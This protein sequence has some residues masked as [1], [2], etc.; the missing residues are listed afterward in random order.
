MNISRQSI[1]DLN[2]VLTVQITKEDYAPQVEKILK[3]YQKTANIPGFRKGHVPMGMIKKQYGKAVLLDEINK[4]MQ[5]SLNSYITQEKLEI[6]GNP[7]PI[8]NPDFD[9]DKEDFSFDFEIGLSP[10]FEVNLKKN[11]ITK[12]K[13]VADTTFLD[14]QIKS[15]R[16]SYGK[17]IAKETVEA[18]DE[19]TGVFSNEEKN[20]NNKATFSLERIKG[21]KQKEALLGKKPGDSVVL[22]TKNLFVDEHD[23]QQYLGV[24]HEQ[25]HGLDIEVSL[26]IEE[27][28]TYELAEIN[29][30]LWDKVFGKDVVKSE[31]EAREKIKGDAEKQFEQY[32]DQVLLNEVVESLIAN[33]QFDLPKDFLIK[34]LEN[35]GEQPMDNE[36]AAA[37]YERTEKGLRYQLIEAKIMSENNLYANFEELKEYA[38]QMIAA[39]M[40]QYGRMDAEDQELETIAARILSNQEEVKRLA[41]QLNQSKMLKFFKENTQLEEKE[42]SYDKFTQE[43]YH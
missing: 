4:L 10:K 37:E 30:E 39:Q 35:G 31:K 33:T 16:K 15:I 24:S 26:T 7:L 17:L 2:A 36:E 1:D 8:E 3:N 43:V 12:Y 40:A 13:V 21:K 32:A 34:W 20:I 41:D 19:I 23:N 25:T 11:P 28:S 29:Q 27:V 42:I 9:L 14:Q 18:E 38:K 5:E 6:L 22:A